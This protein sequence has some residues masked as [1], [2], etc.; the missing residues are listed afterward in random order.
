[1]STDYHYLAQSLAAL[2]GVPVRIYAGGV[3]QKLYHHSKF[4]PDLAILEEPNIFR[5]TANVSYYMDEQFLYYGLFRIQAVDVALIIGPVA[6]ITIDNNT[7]RA[8]LRHIGEPL[9]RTQELMAYFASMPAYPLRNFLQILCTINYFIN[10]DKLD[11]AQLLTGG[12]PFSAAPTEAEL[13]NRS[14][15]IPHNT[16]ELE[17][18]LLSAVQYGRVEE[19]QELFR[20]PTA[21]QAGTMAN[22]T[23]RQQKNLLICTATLVSRAA[24]K[25]GLDY[26]VAFA[27]SD[28]YIQKAELLNHFEALTNLNTQMV[29]DFARRV[30]QQNGD[31]N[32]SALVRKTR[33]Y[34]LKHIDQPIRTEELAR[35]LG[36]NRTYLCTAFKEGCGMTVNRYIASVKMEEA[37]RLLDVTDKSIAEIAYYLG[38]SSQGYFQNSFKKAFGMTP[39]AY[40]RQKD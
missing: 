33:Q 22:N 21:G 10:G 24:I 27:L 26:E 7:A 37:R 34:I 20:E 3:F 13:P 1:M 14:G 5:S 11:T 15:R 40:R 9:S 4:K 2:A 35:K 19:L 25:G 32:H 29:L 8:I 18:R 28:N 31:E 23:L 39:G 6:Q 17:K 16:M 38:F 12:Q 36:M 30:A